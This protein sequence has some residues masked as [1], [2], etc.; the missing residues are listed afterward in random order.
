M[1]MLNTFTNM[2]MDNIKFCGWLV[3]YHEERIDTDVPFFLLEDIHGKRFKMRIHNPYDR[4][5]SAWCSEELEV[6]RLI[7]KKI[8]EQ[9]GCNTDILEESDIA[10][11]INTLRELVPYT[12]ESWINQNECERHDYITPRFIF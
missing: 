8:C 7:G 10:K 11:L 6:V 3:Y 1:Q 12:G 2:K 9:V 5:Y 4:N